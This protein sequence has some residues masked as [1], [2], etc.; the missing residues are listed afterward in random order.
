MKVQ[1][2]AGSQWARLD[3]SDAGEGLAIFFSQSE[4]DTVR[5]RFD[6][7]AKVD[8][9]AELL[10]GWFYVSPP[11]ATDPIGPVTRQVG[12]AVCP[13]AITWSVCASPALGSVSA[14]NESNNITLV[15]SKCCTA[16]VGVTR[17]GERY[18]YLADTSPGAT[19]VVSTILPGRTVTAI[20]AFG[21]AGGG[22]VQINSGPT[23]T[24]PS[25]VGLNLEPKALIQKVDA[26]T[27]ASPTIS[28]TNVDWVIEYLE[29]A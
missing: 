22:T 21:L 26:S 11:S 9:G 23:I 8:N 12:A 17:V 3:D 7:Y 28:M 10:V 5:W 13:G 2:K 18:G 20:S 19:Q 15:S 6:V 4:S 25:G 24:V 29:S 14:T 27:G 16:P 1:A